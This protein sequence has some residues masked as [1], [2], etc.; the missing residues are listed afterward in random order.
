MPQLMLFYSLPL[1][2]LVPS[3]FRALASVQGAQ[4]FVSG[5]GWSDV[6]VV[7]DLG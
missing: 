4:P 6:F 5:S 2:V 1:G 3:V 7:S